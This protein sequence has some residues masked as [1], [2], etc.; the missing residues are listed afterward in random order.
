MQNLV[1]L[2]LPISRTGKIELIRALRQL[3]NAL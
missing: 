2:L 3:I 1:E